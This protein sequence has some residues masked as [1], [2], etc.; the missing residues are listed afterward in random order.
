MMKELF[1]KYHHN[2][3]RF[4]SSGVN[5]FVSMDEEEPYIGS[6]ALGVQLSVPVDYEMQDGNTNLDEV[7]YKMVG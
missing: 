7:D 3:V 1:G 5:S 4:V 2:G 6:R